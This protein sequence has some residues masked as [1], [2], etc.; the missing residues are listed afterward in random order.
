MIS[1]WLLIGIVIVFLIFSI[2]FLNTGKCFFPSTNVPSFFNSQGLYS[3]CWIVAF[4]LLSISWIFLTRFYSMVNK[5][6]F[7]VLLFVL[8]MAE[9]VLMFGWV[10]FLFQLCESNTA[11]LFLSA[12][13]IVNMVLIILSIKIPMVVLF[14]GL[15]LFWLLF[16]FYATY[17]IF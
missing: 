14:L 11:L 12:A 7:V 10:I 3:P 8:F 1:R 2:L 17:N 4:G 5:E 6:I 16:T 15:H 13:I 9:L